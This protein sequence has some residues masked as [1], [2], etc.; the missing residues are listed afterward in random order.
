MKDYSYLR[1]AK[2]EA[3]QKW[4]NAPLVVK[5]T[6]SSV[7]VKDGVILPVRRAPGSSLKYGYGGVVADGVYIRESGIEGRYGGKYS[8]ESAV[9]KTGSTVFCGK[10]NRQW[11]HFLLE[12]V[13]RLWIFLENT[14]E[15]DHYV[16]IVP[17]GEDT[18]ITG[19][20]RGFL[21]LLGI[22][23]YVEVINQPVQYDEV[24]IPELA[25]SRKH[26]YSKQYKLIFETVAQNAQQINNSSPVYDK[27]FLS[28]SHFKKALE[29]ECGLDML[30]HYFTKNGYFILRPETCSLAETIIL[31]RNAKICAAE[32]GTLPHNYLFC[33]DSKDVIIVERQTTVNE[34]QENVDE[35]RNLNVTYIDG[36]YTIDI[37]NAGYGM[38]FL[39]YTDCFRAFTK[40]KGYLDPDE[41]YIS[42]KTL[43]VNLRKYF[44]AYKKSFGYHWGFERWQLMYAD[45]YYEAYE[46]SC[47]DLGPYLSREKALFWTDYFD[48]HILKSEIKAMLHRM[49][50]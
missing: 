24:I 32:S 29:T 14:V 9:K 21:E 40:C 19:N 36:H 26:Y 41:R 42:E 37:P 15:A 44:R 28:R 46:D 2:A 11:G 10:L 7:S 4:N 38:F 49:K 27:V 39:A 33:Q 45:A 22:L 31:L 47:K 23:P 25:Y 18:S 12:S 17:E 35:I 30:D 6:L 50:S 3:L 16:F 48:P 43:R 1:P 20:Y 34:M 13:S 8:F 5:E